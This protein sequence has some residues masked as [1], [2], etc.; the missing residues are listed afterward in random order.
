[1]DAKNSKGGNLEDCHDAKLLSELK[2]YL[3]SEYSF[4]LADY[5][6][7]DKILLTGCRKRWNG[8]DFFRI[9]AIVTDG[10]MVV[11]CVNR[12]D[13]SLAAVIPRFQGKTIEEAGH[14]I[15]QMIEKLGNTS[16]APKK[17]PFGGM[18]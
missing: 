1:M 6:S 9:A 17:A 2:R 8:A 11:R 13:E 14:A 7:H 18:F 10:S 12:K 15:S 16:R 5:Y 3:K 4:Y